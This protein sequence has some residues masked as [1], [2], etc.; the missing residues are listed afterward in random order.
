MRASAVGLFV[1]DVHDAPISIKER[2]L[3]ADAER[4]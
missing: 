3:L 1:A 2:M 4:P